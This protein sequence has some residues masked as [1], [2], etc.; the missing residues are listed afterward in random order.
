MLDTGAQGYEFLSAVYAGIVLGLIYEA[1]RIV[2]RIVNSAVVSAIMDTLFW[3]AA[4]VW[5]FGAF[6]LIN[7]AR[8]RMYLIL[9]IFVGL[10]L[11][12]YSTGII[13]NYICNIVKAWIGNLRNRRYV[14]GQAQ[15][16]I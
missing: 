11:H 12:F 2:R 13:I 9:G 10:L 3:I 8:L 5:V 6:Y 4:G 15:D 7:G 14:D 1:C 16:E